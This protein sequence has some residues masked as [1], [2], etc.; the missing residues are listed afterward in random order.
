RRADPQ[1]KL[2]R[3][4]AAPPARRHGVRRSRAG[5][6]GQLGR[7]ISPESNHRRLDGGARR[8]HPL[9]PELGRRGERLSPL[10]RLFGVQGG[11]RPPVAPVGRG[12]RAARRARARGGPRRHGHRAARGRG[13]RRRPRSARG[14]E[15]RGPAHRRT[16]FGCAR[17]ER[18]ARRGSAVRGG[19]LNAATAPRAVRHAAR[20]LHVD[21]ARDTVAH[22]RALD[23]PRRL[24]PGDLV[25]VND[26]ATL[27]GS[28]RLPELDA[29]VRLVAHGAR[30]GEFTALLFG[31]GD[32]RTPT[33]RRPPPPGVELG[34]R[35]CF[36]GGLE[37]VV[38]AVDAQAPRLIQ[39]GFSRSG[40]ELLQAL[41]RL[42]RPVQYAHVPEALEVW[43]VQN[44]YGGRPW[45]FE[46][47]SAG[48]ALYGELLLALRQ[49]GV[50]IAT[51]THAAGIS[52]TGSVALDRRFPLPERFEIPASTVAAIAA[53]R[54]HGGRV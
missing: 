1:R 21:P 22:G 36:G 15:R 54:A 28:L 39:L 47:P 26:A 44:R 29:E 11:P 4:H 35:L 37:A 42:G 12:A 32:H 48:C 41:Y 25:I 38:T 8:R 27:P 17:P 53:A 5:A 50:A 49:R 24:R 2:P 51:L 3:P 7:A 19:V 46:L 40:A 52:S 31:P 34:Q 45:G 43:D 16:P 30:P 20:L 14:P 13:A 23:L 9:A 18:R 10:G 33:E 6:G